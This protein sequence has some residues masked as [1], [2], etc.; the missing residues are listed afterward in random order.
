[1]NGTKRKAG[2]IALYAAVVG[3]MALS[4][5]PAVARPASAAQA[6]RNLGPNNIPVAGRFLEVWTSAGSEQNS[7]YVNGYPI[8][9]RRAEISVDDGKVY[10]TQWF[11]RARYEAHPENKA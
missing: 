8:T 6:S 9:P 5:A 4:L 7:V 11:E 10:D 3:S 1:M 2:P